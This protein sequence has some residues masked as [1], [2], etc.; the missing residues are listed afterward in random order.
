MANAENFNKY[1]EITDYEQLYYQI[2]KEQKERHELRKQ[3]QNNGR[4]A[5]TI[6][7]T[8]KIKKDLKAKILIVM[9]QNIEKAKD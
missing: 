9:F 4:E 1:F 6:L 7:N 3:Y 2:D 8:S 5:D